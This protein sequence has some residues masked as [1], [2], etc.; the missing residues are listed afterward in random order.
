MGIRMLVV[1]LV[2][3]LVMGAGVIGWLIDTAPDHADVRLERPGSLDPEAAFDFS[4]WL[5]LGVTFGIGIVLV[6]YIFFRAAQRL[7][8]GDDLYAQRLGRGVRRRGE[9]YLGGATSDEST[10]P[11]NDQAPA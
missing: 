11:R 6:G 4:F 1:G 2:L 7:R 8:A 3:A 10:A 5:P 9:R